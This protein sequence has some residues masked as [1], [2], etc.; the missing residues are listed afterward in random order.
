MVNQKREKG[1]CW[2]GEREEIA[3]SNSFAEGIVESLWKRKKLKFS[4]DCKLIFIMGQN[5]YLL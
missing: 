3:F 4:H 5:I 2:V 1:T